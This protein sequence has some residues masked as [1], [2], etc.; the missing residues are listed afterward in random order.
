ML[1]PVLYLL[2]SLGFGTVLAAVI[3]AIALHAVADYLNAT[4]GAHRRQRADR[5][6]KRIIGMRNTT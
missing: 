5:T 1:D 3:Y 4:V 2:D 6:L